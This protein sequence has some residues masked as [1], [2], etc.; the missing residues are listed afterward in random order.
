M[1]IGV[2]HQAVGVALGREELIELWRAGVVGQAEA[3]PM[4][5]VLVWFLLSGFV[6]IL[7][8]WV[9]HRLEVSGGRFSRGIALGFDALCAAGVLLMP[10]SGFW[11]G[12]IPA[13]QF[14]RRATQ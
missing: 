12:F 7:T 13:V 5:M 2:I 6:L 14:W 9:T 11:L 1:A 10:A 3:N 4:R 8:G